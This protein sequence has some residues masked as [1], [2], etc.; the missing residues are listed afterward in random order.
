MQSAW[1]SCPQGRLITRLTP[2]IYSSKQTT[3]STCLPIY[4]LHSAEKPLAPFS[5]SFRALPRAPVDEVGMAGVDAGTVSVSLSG[6]PVVVLE[7][8][9]GREVL[10]CRRGVVGEELVG[11]E[12][13]GV[14]LGDV[15]TVWY[16]RTG[17]LS[18]TDFGARHLRRRMRA[19]RIRSA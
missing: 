1:N 3:H 6:I 8:G 7:R 12:V 10:C 14:M 19:R 15:A 13:P 4:F 2:S 17:S 18:T 16:V 11:V 9:R 5:C